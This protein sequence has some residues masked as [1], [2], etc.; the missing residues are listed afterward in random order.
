MPLTYY[1]PNKNITGCGLSL[2]ANAKQE[3]VFASLIKQVKFNS[4]GSR[5][6]EFKGGAQVN[7]K[8]NPLD[9]ANI[10]L[11]VR[12]NTPYSTVHQSDKATT[13]IAFDPY[14]GKDNVQRGFGLKVHRTDKAT[15]EKAGWLIGFNFAE[16]V[17]LAEWLDYSLDHI[18]NQW[19]SDDK[20]RGEERAKQVKSEPKPQETDNSDLI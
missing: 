11:C 7:I 16:A 10:L 1:K 15:Q 17:L 19:Y 13:V 5:G 2:S 18:F 4:D 9:I 20:K 12:K 14:M 3:C 8:L 6:G